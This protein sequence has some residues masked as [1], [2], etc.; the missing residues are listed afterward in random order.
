MISHH[1]GNEADRTVTAFQFARVPIN[2]GEKKN[3]EEEM[4]RETR[5]AYCVAEPLAQLALGD[6]GALAD[7]KTPPLSFLKLSPATP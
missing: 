3:S 2:Q 6:R 7:L 1:E 5:R 4:E